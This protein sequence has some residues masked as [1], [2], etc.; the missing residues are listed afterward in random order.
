MGQQRKPRGQTYRPLRVIAQGG[1]ATRDVGN[2]GPGLGNQTAN[3]QAEQQGQVRDELLDFIRARLGAVQGRHAKETDAV[4][5]A[6]SW[7]RR[8][9][10]Q[11]PHMQLPEPTRW[12]ACI[13]L[14]KQA[15]KA[16][17]AGQLGRAAHLLEKALDMEE[18]TIATYPDNLR[19]DEVPDLAGPLPQSAVLI[20]PADRCPGTRARDIL[21]MADR[22]LAQNEGVTHIKTPGTPKRRSWLHDIEEDT[23]PN[24]DNDDE[25]AEEG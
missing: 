21:V 14:Y 1:N 16:L 5:S 25:E 24:D 3:E 10:L 9:G 17:C 23:E 18:A 8:V 6:S 11:D 22:M 19:N 4:S 7:K 2:S 12:N 20:G 15:T 13:R